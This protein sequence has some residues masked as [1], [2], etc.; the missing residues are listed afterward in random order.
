MSCCRDCVRLHVE[1][2]QSDQPHHEIWCGCG[3]FDGIERWEDLDSETACEDF[4]SE[5]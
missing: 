2:P 5:E 3:H 1:M 4:E